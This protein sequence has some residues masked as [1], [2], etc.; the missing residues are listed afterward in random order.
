MNTVNWTPLMRLNSCDDQLDLFQRVVHN[1]M[2]C[3]PL[4]TVKQHPNDKPWITPA[5]REFIQK[6]QQAWLNDDLPLYKVYRNKVIKLCKK[7][8][9]KFYNDKI[10]NIHESNPKKW[11]DGI[12]LLSRLS[13]PL[14]ITSIAVNGTILS[15]FDLAVAINES[16]C[17]VADDI[18]QL[19]FT[20]IRCR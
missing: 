2:D 12:K 7:A 3:I 19:N 20:P 1:A 17:S 15:G 9:H 11:W 5:I 10:N 14:P 8:H 4:R 18:P 6:H 13:N 16:F